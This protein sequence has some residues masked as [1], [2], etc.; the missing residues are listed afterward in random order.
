MAAARTIDSLATGTAGSPAT[1]GDKTA[2]SDA[3][4]FGLLPCGRRRRDRATD[5]SSGTYRKPAATRPTCVR[6]GFKALSPSDPISW[7]RGL[8]NPRSPS[9]PHCG[10]Q[11]RSG[12]GR[13]H[14]QCGPRCPASVRRVRAMSRAGTANRNGLAA[15]SRVLP[16]NALAKAA[17][18]S[19]EEESSRI[20]LRG[21][22][23]GHLLVKEISTSTDEELFLHLP[24][25][26]QSLLRAYDGTRENPKSC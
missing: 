5:L 19:I 17:I 3:V 24:T 14:R 22:P 12:C 26:C 10:C 1:A 21:T 4:C 8:P 13:R 6:I 20:V 2:R 25:V 18:G 9:S 11:D 23:Q 7:Y 16:R 15:T